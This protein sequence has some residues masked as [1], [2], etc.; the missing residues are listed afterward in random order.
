MS[1]IR[2]SVH[3]F[4]LKNFYVGNEGLTDGESLLDRGIVD[5]TGILEVIAY[6]EETFGI[7]V[8][9]SEIL[10]EHLDSVGAIVRFV[11]KKKA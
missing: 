5:S 10:P 11:E 9:D 4:L 1:S 2:D 3:A 8:E 7:R 6:L